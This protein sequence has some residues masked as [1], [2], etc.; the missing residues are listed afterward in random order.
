M[1]TQKIEMKNVP[2]TETINKDDD[3]AAPPKNQIPAQPE[4]KKPS[5]SSSTPDQKQTTAEASQAIITAITALCLLLPGKFNVPSVNARL[6]QA[7]RQGHSPESL[8]R[9]LKWCIETTN[10]THYKKFLGYLG[11]S[12]DNGYAVNPEEDQ[13]IDEQEI[14]KKRLEL[15]LEWL[16]IDAEQGNRYSQKALELIKGKG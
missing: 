8:E 1:K 12:I 14:M 10:A 7:T 9:I 16:K 15:P 6:M 3:V 11:K 13:V 4:T 2:Y 5:P